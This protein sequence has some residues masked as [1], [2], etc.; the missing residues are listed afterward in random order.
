MEERYQK[1]ILDP[2]RSVIDAYVPL[3]QTTEYKGKTWK[4][5]LTELEGAGNMLPVLKCTGESSTS[6]EKL[7]GKEAFLDR[8][9]L[10]RV[11]NA[12]G[13]ESD[14]PVSQGKNRQLSPWA[15]NFFVDVN[16]KPDL[17]RETALFWHLPKVSLS[18]VYSTFHFSC[19]INHISSSSVVSL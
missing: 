15:H 13:F 2:L 14:Q 6:C 7:V 17:S 4:E 1:D 5:V 12:G 16:K 3:S 8:K 11:T 18:I 9:V 19:I 10:R